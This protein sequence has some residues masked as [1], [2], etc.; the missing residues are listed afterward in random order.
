MPTSGSVDFSVS[1]DNI[2]YDALSIVGA[3]GPDDTPAASWIT[4]AAR[5]LNK[6]VKALGSRGPSLWA[7]KVGYILPVSATNTVLLGPTGGHATLSYVHTLLSADASAGAST[8]DVDS[9]TGM[10]SGDYIG[11]ELDDDSIQW[12]TINGAPSG[13]TVTL[14]ATLTGDAADNGHVYTY[15]T[16]LQ[17]PLRILDA[18]LHNETQ[19]TDIQVDVVAKLD[20]DL[21]GSKTDEGVV[22]QLSYEPLL[23]NGVAY[24]A[25]R[26][27]DGSR[28]I[29]IIFQRPFEDFDASG[30]TPDFPQEWYDYL[31]LAT[32]LRIA[33]VY[34]MPVQDRALL[35]AEAKEAL[36]LV[37]GNEPEEGSL[38]ISPELP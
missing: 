18:Y 33:P 20:Y 1:R 9:I 37:S 11:V 30:D 3:I 13:S 38:R 31:T 5:Q 22:N 15:T 14:T 2:L 21:L 16:K 7:K 26:F 35:K 12:T 27:E 25:P 17:R 36:D 32:A 29:T 23:T 19:L 6:I 4:H 10:S 24:F 34:G 28:T 8:I